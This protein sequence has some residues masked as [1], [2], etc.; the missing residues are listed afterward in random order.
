MPAVAAVGAAWWG[1][2]GGGSK[3]VLKGLRDEGL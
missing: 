1:S 3:G 2:V